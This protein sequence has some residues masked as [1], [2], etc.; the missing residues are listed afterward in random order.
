MLRI[1]VLILAAVILPLTAQAVDPTA[2][3]VN[4]VGETMSR[5][6]MTTGLVSNDIL[7]LG[8]D[9][10]CAPNQIVIRDTLAYVINSLTDEIQII[11][12]NTEATVD[13]IDLPAGS[14]P[15]WMAFYD[16]RYAYVTLLKNNSVARVDVISRTLVQEDSVGLSPGGITICNYKAYIGVT[17]LNDEY[18]YGQGKL[19]IYDIRGD[20]LLKQ[21]NVGKNP[22][23]L[24]V[25]SAGRVHV[26]CTGDY[27]SVWG[28]VY[29]ID[30]DTDIII[31]SLYLGGSPGGIAIGPDN[32]AYL[33]AGGWVSDGYLYAYDAQTLTVLH[34]V[35]SPLIVGYGCMG[36]VAYQD[37][38]VFSI[39]YFDSIEKTDTSGVIAGTYAVGDVPVHL[40]F[41]YL[42]GDVD[43]DW[44]VDI[45][46]LTCLIDYLFISYQE[47]RYPRW[48]ADVDAVFGCDIGDITHLISYLF[49]GG[50]NPIAGPAWLR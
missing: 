38:T 4:S 13:F 6:D 36:A 1:C 49:L 17:S 10:E 31:D 29:L 18:V 42:P 14:N 50:P 22:N 27:W 47:P 34:D 24:A 11:N 21:F 3:V 19:A 26:V 28:I 46:D 35:G 48:R 5:I 45:G 37:T 8:S 33:A 2:Y 12:L 16:D 30:S 43:G 25:D 9:V 44:V 41:N 23:N 39:G 32:V 40:D 20:S 15:Y 7:T